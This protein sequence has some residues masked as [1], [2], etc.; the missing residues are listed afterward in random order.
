[1]E[2]LEQETDALFRQADIKCKS[3]EEMSNFLTHLIQRAKLKKLAIVEAHVD[4]QNTD[5]DLH[6]YD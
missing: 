1:M 6:A 2:Q 4:M 3:P 5:D